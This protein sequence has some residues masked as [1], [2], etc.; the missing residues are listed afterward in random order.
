MECWWITSESEPAR[1]GQ[2][3]NLKTDSPFE[4]CLIGNSSDGHILDG[5]PGRIEHRETFSLS[6]WFDPRDYLSERS[7]DV[8]R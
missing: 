1:S 4:G 5:E 3:I 2:E 8:F 7:R 6:S